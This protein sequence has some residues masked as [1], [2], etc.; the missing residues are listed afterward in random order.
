MAA[1]VT[2]RWARIEE[3]LP[4]IRNNRKVMKDH[5]QH[6][7]VRDGAT[8]LYVAGVDELVDHLLELHE[9]DVLSD[10]ADLLEFTYGGVPA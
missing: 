7:A 3:L 5:A 9:R 10:V 4:R 8:R 2:E 6:P 1:S